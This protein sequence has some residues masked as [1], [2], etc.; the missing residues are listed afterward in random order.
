MAAGF[1]W[2]ANAHG[3]RIPSEVSLVG[4][5]NSILSANTSPGITTI[6]Q[7]LVEIGVA[8]VESLAAMIEGKPAQ[9]QT[10]STRLIERASTTSP[11]EDKNKP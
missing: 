10:F 9:G 6:E 2:E 7:P 8:A 4:F 3:M 5:D 11:Q 1:I